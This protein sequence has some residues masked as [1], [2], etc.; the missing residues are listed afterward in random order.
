MCAFAPTT[1]T[2]HAAPLKDTQNDALARK[3]IA[4]KRS[5]SVGAVPQGLNQCWSLDFASE[6]LVNGRRFRVLFIIDDFSQECL[7]TVVN[8]SLSGQ[9]IV[10]ELDRIAEVRG[11]PC[12][13]V[14]DHDTELSSKAILHW[15]QERGVEWRNISPGKPWRKGFVE[16]FYG[17][18][19]NG[20]RL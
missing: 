14:S 8:T 18:L 7:A 17:L 13:V 6:R 4:K 10:R 12:M 9:R 15:Q 19:R 1:L 16:R 2:V 11:Y 5:P 20:R 3:T